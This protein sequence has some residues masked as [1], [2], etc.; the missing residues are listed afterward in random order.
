MKS[1]TKENAMKSIQ[2]APLL[3]FAFLAD[4]AVSAAA[5]ALHLLLPRALADWLLLPN[6]LLLG[7]GAFL[8][9]Y[10]ALLLVFA[11]SKSIWR[12]LVQIVIAGN[13]AWALA[14]LGLLSTA[15][16]RPS[17]PGVAFLIV[18][19]VAV[20]AFAALELAGLKRSEAAAVILAHA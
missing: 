13:V 19:I 2:P 3:K 5:A 10:A 6:I 20:L 14:C 12:A 18:Q 4:A 15:A 8:A 11:R 7:T 1:T 9:A 16:V 17:A